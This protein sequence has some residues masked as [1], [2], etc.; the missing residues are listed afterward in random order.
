MLQLFNLFF[1][2]EELLAINEY[3]FRNLY[4]LDFTFFIVFYNEYKFVEYYY[5]ILANFYVVYKLLK[6]ITTFVRFSMLR[7]YIIFIND[8]AFFRLGSLY[9]PLFH[10]LRK[11]IIYNFSYY[12]K[13]YFKL[14]KKRKAYFRLGYMGYF[15]LFVFLC[16][17]FVFILV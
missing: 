7:A 1:T 12:N 3:F 14:R 6:R 16:A 15:Q 4:F 8:T 17:F 5:Y 10:R 11:F 2:L 13:A 9:L